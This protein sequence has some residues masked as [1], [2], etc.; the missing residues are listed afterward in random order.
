MDFEVDLDTMLEVIPRNTYFQEPPVAGC[1]NCPDFGWKNKLGF[2]AAN[3]YGVNVAADGLNEA[4]YPNPA[5]ERSEFNISKP[6]ITSICSYILG[7]FASVDEV[8]KGLEDVQPAGINGKVAQNILHIPAPT[9]G[10]DHTAPFHVSIH[11]RNGKNL[12]IEFLKGKT[13]ILENPNGV[14]TNDPPLHKQLQLLQR[15]LHNATGTV[16]S[17]VIVPGGYSSTDRFVRLSVLNKMSEEGYNVTSVHASYAN[18]LSDEQRVVSDTL[19]LLNTVVRPPN[20][21]ATQWSIVRD[22]KRRM[23]YIRSTT[24]Q[25]LRRVDLNQLDWTNPLARRMIPVSYGKYFVDMTKPLLDEQ[26]TRR[27]KDLSP[28]SVVESALSKK[29]DPS[30]KLRGMK[31][32][33]QMMVKMNKN[34]EA[35]SQD[36]TSIAVLE[37]KVEY[38]GYAICLASVA[39]CILSFR[40]PL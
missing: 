5:N 28:R 6:V 9:T 18:T 10:K 16:N 20:G 15:H 4:E 13:I 12:V 40:L 7:N 3:V 39:V 8:I 1:P 25:L 29:S 17:S 11:D 19:H 33:L 35:R 21:E 31:T 37:R 38:L 30:V 27:T 2:L 26:N 32:P 24:N 22:H 36:D 23:L 34:D 14:L